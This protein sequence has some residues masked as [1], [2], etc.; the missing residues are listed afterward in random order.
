ML[1]SALEL[2]RQ[3]LLTSTIE[4]VLKVNRGNTEPTFAKEIQ[5][6]TLPGTSITNQSFVLNAVCR[7]CRSWNGGSLDVTSTTQPWM[8]AFGPTNDIM[9]DSPS[10]PLRRHRDYGT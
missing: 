8:Y 6:E 7:N 2:L 3:S 9:S 10:A 4:Y 1:L 5:I